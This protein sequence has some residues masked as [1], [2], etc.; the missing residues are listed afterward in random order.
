VALAVVLAA[1]AYSSVSSLDASNQKA[2]AL[3]KATAAVLGLNR[4]TQLVDTD[5]MVLATVPTN[6]AHELAVVEAQYAKAVSAAQAQAETVQALH[7][8]GPAVA[9]AVSRAG[10]YLA[11]AS[12]LTAKLAANVPGSKAGWALE[13]A[14]FAAAGRVSAA[15]D[16]ARAYLQA[17]SAAAAAA[18]GNEANSVHAELVIFALVGL[19]VLVAASALIARS[20]T[21]PVRRSVGA[22]ERVAGGDYTVQIDTTGTD[23]VGDMSRALA[24]AVGSVRHAFAE[25]H[26]CAEALGSASEE[27][28]AISQ[29]MS[30]HSEETATQANAV[31]AAAE[32][33]SSN[34]GAV[35]ASAEEMSASIAEIARSMGE[36]T[37]VAQEGADM[38]QSTG[39]TVARLGESSSEIG[40]VVKAITSIAQ[41]TNLLALNATIEAARAGEAGRGFAIVANEV[42]ELAKETAKATEDIASR[43]EAIQGDSGAAISAIGGIAGI[44]GKINE[45]QGTIASAVEEQTATTGEIGRAVHEAAAG[46]AEIARNVA[47]V[48]ASAEEASMGASNSK[49]AA[50]E[51]ARLAG[52]LQQLLA[53]VT[54]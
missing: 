38:A 16:S 18:A 48:A 26:G 53:G 49:Q 23:E 50:G 13:E 29:Q 14:Q 11:Q 33:I 1:V 43:I 35:A 46:S 41:Q 47:G 34:V 7:A 19:A 45:A 6:L 24:T 42:K 9:N 21:G 8:S 31:S 40:E 17:A 4:D 20:V 37:R 10:A 51:L 44:M 22:L 39:A 30:G 3:A 5:E 52:S 28:A 36:A 2:A 12:A 32:Q 27:L 15:G 54:Y 25:I